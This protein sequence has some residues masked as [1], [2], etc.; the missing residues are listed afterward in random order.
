MVGPGGALT[1]TA[2][3]LQS[4]S[5]HMEGWRFCKEPGPKERAWPHRQRLPPQK[6]PA[7]TERA[8]SLAQSA[9]AHLRQLP[10]A[11]RAEDCVLSTGGV[12]SYVV[13]CACLHRAALPM[14]LWMS[15][16]LLQ[17]CSSNATVD[18]FVPV[19]G[20]LLQCNCG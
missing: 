6:G 10:S 15:L 11:I 4:T 14:Q 9:G 7:P 16:C 17:G 12:C 3:S 8:W 18:E 20:L 5:P 19:T 2:L 13:Q 1:A